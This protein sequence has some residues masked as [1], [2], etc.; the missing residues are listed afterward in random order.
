M[1][2][3]TIGHVELLQESKEITY[4]ANNKVS[5]IISKNHKEYRTWKIK[6]NFHVDIFFNV[7][8]P[9]RIWVIIVLTFPS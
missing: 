2:E 5:Y 6:A 8:Y 7:S 1:Y 4:F 3:E 9:C